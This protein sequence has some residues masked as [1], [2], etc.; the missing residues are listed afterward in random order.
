MEKRQGV[1]QKCDK[2]KGIIYAHYKHTYIHKN[3][4]IHEYNSN[5]EDNVEKCM[6]GCHKQTRFL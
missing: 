5:V 6:D 4:N 1:Q 3:N 2:Y